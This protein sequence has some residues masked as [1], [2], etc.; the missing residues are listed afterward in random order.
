LE[1]IV[2][3]RFGRVNFTSPGGGLREPLE[4]QPCQR[5]FLFPFT[6]FQSLVSSEA[7]GSQDPPRITPVALRCRRSTAK[8][9]GV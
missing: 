1:G 6:P 5:L 9:Q 8:R 4:Q 3:S 2:F 7:I